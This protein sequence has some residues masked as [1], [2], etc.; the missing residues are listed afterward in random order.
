MITTVT[1]PALALVEPW[2]LERAGAMTSSAPVLRLRAVSSL[3]TRGVAPD[4]FHE[5][6]KPKISPM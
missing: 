1:M 6:G 4:G 5:T 2:T 3:Q